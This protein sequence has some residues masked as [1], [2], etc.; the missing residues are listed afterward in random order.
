MP[1]TF[2]FATESSDLLE[3]AMRAFA[4]WAGEN[5]TMT[6]AEART[7]NEPTDAPAAELPWPHSHLQPPAA[8]A[9]RRP[10]PA[11]I[12]LYLLIIQGAVWQLGWLITGRR[13]GRLPIGC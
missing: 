10:V 5:W 9:Q 12:H 8:L 11:P 2:D 6:E 3:R 7:L 1:E 4:E 13:R